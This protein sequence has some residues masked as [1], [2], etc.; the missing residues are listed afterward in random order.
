MVIIFNWI[1]A[2]V[3]SLHLK[4]GNYSMLIVFLS[5]CKINSVFLLP[6]IR[7]TLFTVIHNCVARIQLLFNIEIYK[8]AQKNAI[9]NTN[10]LLFYSY[11]YSGTD[12][13]E[14]HMQIEQL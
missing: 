10:A 1:E 12:E 8:F 6:H 9:W 14:A 7:T 11:M 4:I 13:W 5:I 2:Q 3:E